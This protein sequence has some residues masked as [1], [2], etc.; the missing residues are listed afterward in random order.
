MVAAAAGHFYSINALNGTWI[1]RVIAISKVPFKRRDEDLL[2][3]IPSDGDLPFRDG[4]Y[5][6]IECYCFVSIIYKY[7]RQSRR[8]NYIFFRSTYMGT[9]T[10]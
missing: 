9:L 4:T 10:G 1:A 6:R 2:Y 5:I 8:T 7:C 3:R